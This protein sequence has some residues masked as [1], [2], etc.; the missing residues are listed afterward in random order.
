[1][2]LNTVLRFRAC[3]SGCLSQSEYRRDRNDH[4]PVAQWLEQRIYIP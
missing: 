2:P 3:I 1:M 4:A